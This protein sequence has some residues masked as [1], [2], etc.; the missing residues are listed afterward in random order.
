MSM[1]S[2]HP[3]NFLLKRMYF[4]ATAP[5]MMRGTVPVFLVF[6]DHRTGMAEVSVT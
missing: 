1:F 2:E 3:N 4:G 5:R 6:D